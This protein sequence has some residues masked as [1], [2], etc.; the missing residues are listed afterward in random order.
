MPEKYQSYMRKKL[1]ATAEETGRNPLIAEGMADVNLVI[2]SI[3]PKGKIITFTVSEA[4]K[5][6]Y[7]NAELESPEQILPLLRGGPYTLEYHKSTLSESLALWLINPAVSGILLLVIFGGIYFEF[8]APGTLLPICASILAA[9]LYFAPLYVEG[10]A[11]NWE[12]A[13]FVVGLVLI[14]VEIFVTPGSIIIGVAGILATITGLALALVR[15]IDFDFTFVAPGALAYAFLMVTVAMALPL[16][17]IMIFGKTMF[18]SAVFKNISDVGEMKSSKG[19]SIKDKLLHSMVGETGIAVT[20]LRPAG[21]IE[22]NNER[23]DAITDG[24]FIEKGQ[25]VKVLRLQATYLVVTLD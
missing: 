2:D 17:F 19:Y 1:Q 10:L 22:I 7:C 16:I 9:L 23:Y 5:Y 8:K 15:N 11:A 14:I 4:I 18:N 13:L 24:G 3:K 20:N 12:I 6:G 25:A 21:K